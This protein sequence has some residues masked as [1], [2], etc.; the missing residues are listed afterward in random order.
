MRC[1]FGLSRTSAVEGS[2]QERSEKKKDE[3]HGI[4]GTVVDLVWEA[5]LSDSYLV[6]HHSFFHLSLVSIR[7]T[8]YWHLANWLVSHCT[9]KCDNKKR[10]DILTQVAQT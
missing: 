9:I 2:Y 4:Y 6:H 3:M 8:Y 7:I 10:C 1:V 5:A